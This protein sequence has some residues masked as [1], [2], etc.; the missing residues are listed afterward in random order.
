MHVI[1]G[2]SVIAFHEDNKEQKRQ[3]LIVSKTTVKYEYEY[4]E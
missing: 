2:S 4:R 1:H 3:H